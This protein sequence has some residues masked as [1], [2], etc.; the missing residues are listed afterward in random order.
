MNLQLKAFSIQFPSISKK[1]LLSFGRFP[2]FAHLS[3]YEQRVD[4]DE[5][6]ALVE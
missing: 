4:E 2:G 3:W 6:R 5:Y 1:A